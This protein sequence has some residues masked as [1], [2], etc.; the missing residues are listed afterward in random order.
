MVFSSPGN[1]NQYHNFG[2]LSVYNKLLIVG[3]LWNGL[4]EGPPP[5]YLL[6]AQLQV[7][8]ICLKGSLAAVSS[9][10]TRAFCLTTHK[11]NPL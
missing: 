7:L 8:V 6:K 2:L 10:N 4:F 5:R 11:G 9:A 1:T 3:P